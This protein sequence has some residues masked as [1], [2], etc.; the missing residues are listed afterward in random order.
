MFQMSSVSLSPPLFPPNSSSS[1]SH[2][3]FPLVKSTSFSTTRLPEGPPPN[4]LAPL[5][6]IRPLTRDIKLSTASLQPDDVFLAKL[7]KLEKVLKVCVNSH[8][9]TQEEADVGLEVFNDLRFVNQNDKQ[10]WV[11]SFTEE[12]QRRMGNS[13][14]QVMCKTVVETYCA[15]DTQVASYMHVV[16]EEGEG[17]DDYTE[18]SSLEG[19][20]YDSYDEEENENDWIED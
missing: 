20:Y 17:D 14:N 10:A 19:D 1:S 2:A 8:I 15:P 12:L 7:E 16:H 9:F 4:L 13:F 11:S 3:H 5:T 6:L 18:G